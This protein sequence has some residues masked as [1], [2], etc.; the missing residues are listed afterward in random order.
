MQTNGEVSNENPEYFFKESQKG[1]LKESPE[2]LL[3]IPLEK[4]NVKF[5]NGLVEKNPKSNF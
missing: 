3:R 4:I 1:V 2:E 5:I